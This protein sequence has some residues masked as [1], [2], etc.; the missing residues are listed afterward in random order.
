MFCAKED[1]DVIDHG[2]QRAGV[3]NAGEVGSIAERS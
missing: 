3:W 2:G 1:R